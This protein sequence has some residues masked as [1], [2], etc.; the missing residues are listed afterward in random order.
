[1]QLAIV[2]SV[3]YWTLLLAMPHL[4]L[5]DDPNTATGAE[6][7]ASSAVPESQRL[8]LQTDL[9]L[10]AAPAIALF[11][12]FYFFQRKYPKNISCYGAMVLAAVLGTWYSCWVEYCASYNGM[13][14]YFVLNLNCRY[15]DVIYRQSHTP[16][17]PTILSTSASVYILAQVY[18]LLSP[19]RCSTHCTLDHNLSLYIRNI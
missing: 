15:A 7:T 14:T 2:I 19:S 5:P 16:S 11:I 4:I 1:M 9:A 8:P 6:P 18:S 17:S 12:D 13:C 3:I 10:H